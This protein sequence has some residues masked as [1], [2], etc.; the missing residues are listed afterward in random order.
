MAAGQERSASYHLARGELLTALYELPV[1]AWKQSAAKVLTTF[2]RSE[3]GECPSHEVY[4]ILQ[5]ACTCMTSACFSQCE[6][7]SS[8]SWPQTGIFPRP[9]HSCG[10]FQTRQ[11][12]TIAA[13]YA[14][15]AYGQVETLPWAAHG[16]RQLCYFLPLAA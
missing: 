8:S 16:S 2:S 1:W 6:D 15:P 12:R 14:G 11:H 9:T 10:S 4:C 7:D 13:M 3:V 5:Q